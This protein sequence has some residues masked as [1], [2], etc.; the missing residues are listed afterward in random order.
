M[1]SKSTAKV[2]AEQSVMTDVNIL[3]PYGKNPRVGD[4]DAIRES[5]RENGFFAP[6]I[7]Q[8]TTNSI[9][10]GNHRWKAAVAE[11]YKEVPVVY[12]DVDDVAAKKIVLA[13]NRTNDLATYNTEILSEILAGLPTPVGTGYDDQAVRTLLAGMQDKNADMIQDIVRPPVKVE[14]EGAGDDTDWDLTNAV[15]QQKEYHDQRFGDAGN[16]SI[17]IGTGTDIEKLRV[18][19]SIAALQYEFDKHMG[20]KWPSSN[21][22]GIPDLRPDMLLDELP[23]KLQT[24]GG[25][26]A[27][28]DDGESHY[29]WN[30]GL[31]ASKGLPWDRAIA[32][33]FTYDTKFDSWMDQPSF[34]VARVMHNGMTRAIV[35]DTSFWLDDPRFVHLAAAYN[36]QWVGRFMQECGMK[37]IPRFMWTDLESIK[38]GALGIPKKP[39]IAAVCI[40]A[41][42]KKEAEQ[43]M[44]PEGL[45][46]YVK[47]IQ[48]DAL[49]VYGG[50]TAKEVVE[51]AVLPK[52]LHVV[53]VDNYAAVR[54][55]VVYD[56]QTGKTLV[57]KEQRKTAREAARAAKNQA[58]AADNA[59]AEAVD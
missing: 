57:E 51:K 28:P 9:L 36:A 29:I 38:Y 46:L 44:T 12:V 18:A 5:I 42:S 1:G 20:A 22:W 49:I 3:Q 53:H 13:D 45:R 14:F 16:Q 39:P 37:V 23:D 25:Q 2:I 6:L 41:I 33:F 55:H 34:Q 7:V 15:N 54:R 27:T 40:Q 11:G 31:A 43:Q 4:L 35:P 10:A 58:K 50:G 48:P 56:N 52:S 26:D 30:A 47:D 59:E 17:T 24:W 8:K 32:A 21:Y 19:E